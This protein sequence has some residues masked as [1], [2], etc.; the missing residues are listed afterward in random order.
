[1]SQ[2]ERTSSIADNPKITV[3]MH[4]H[5]NTHIISHVLVYHSNIQ[6]PHIYSFLI[7]ICVSSEENLAA[8]DTKI[9][10]ATVVKF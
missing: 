4:V 2:L 10:G 1:M 9:R 3:G 7:A 8:C 5:D 6:A